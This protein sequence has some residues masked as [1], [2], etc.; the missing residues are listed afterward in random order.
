M[1]INMSLKNILMLTLIL[2]STMPI[3]IVGF[4]SLQSHNINIENEITNKNQ[5]LTKSISGDLERFLNDS[6]SFLKQIAYVV[7]NKNLVI[8]E[9][10]NNYLSSIINNYTYFDMIRILDINGQV[11]NLAPF[12][13]N[14]NELDMSFQKYFTE[15]ITTKN[16]YWSKTFISS[17]TSNPTLT[18]SLPFKNGVVVGHL[19][20]SGLMKIVENINFGSSGFASIIDSDGTI[21]A[22]P[23]KIFV[24]ERM[25]VGNRYNILK[26]LSKKNNTF[27]YDFMG[28][29][30]ISS[31]IIIPQTKWIIEVSQKKDEAFSSIKSGRIIIIT[32][33]IISILIAVLIGFIT[34][35]KVLRSLQQL[36]F[37]SQRFARGDYTHKPHFSPYSEINNLI[38]SFK[39]MSE[40]VKNRENELKNH[41]DH[42]EEIVKRRTAELESANKD[43]ESFNYSI[44]HDLRAP[45]RAMEG[46]SKVLSEDYSNKLDEDGIDY[47]NRIIGASQKMSDLVNNILK[48]SRITRQ[49]I[50]IK[51]FN[52][53]NM[54]RK[55]SIDLM[56]SEKDRN[57]EFIIAE[58]INV[59]GDES[60]IEIAMQN[61]LSNAVKYT[62]KVKEAI[63]EFGVKKIKGIKTFYIK[64]NGAGFDMSYKDD[65]FIP[66]KRLHSNN[67]FSGT[68]VG[69][70]I[71]N[72]IIL[73]H[74]GNIWAESKKGEGAAFYFALGKKKQ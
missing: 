56:D 4:I 18:V 70:S 71:V 15:P 12:D 63:I 8:E 61:I 73:K 7:E 39:T 52:L 51:R 45:L 69:L 1:K 64:D 37:D 16:I 55:I 53:S 59:Y 57:I 60:L 34:L 23:N 2:L 6:I 31:V 35:Q 24:H 21:I 65:L 40:A 20:L 48:L 13:E 33:T 28:E 32:G 42:L 9:N 74:G 58:N 54:I 29:R 50:N 43:L 25:N 41:R 67:D 38:N 17:Q 30:R 3:L 72:R 5:L 44:S 14:I 49:E 27:E 68:G 36:T 26:N 62:S 22:H 66:F 10:L 11:V 47:L 19:N 46:F